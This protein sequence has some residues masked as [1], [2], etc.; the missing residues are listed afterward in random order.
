APGSLVGSK[1]AAKN[2]FAV[3]PKTITGTATIQHAAATKNATGGLAKNQPS[4]VVAN[5]KSASSAVNVARSKTNTTMPSLV[6]RGPVTNMLHLAANQN[7]APVTHLPT[8]PRTAA[9][10]LSVRRR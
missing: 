1:A 7:R 10:N 6:Q 3:D 2:A 9:A 4:P 8:A 5:R